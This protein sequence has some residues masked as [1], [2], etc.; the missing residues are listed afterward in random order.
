VAAAL[1]AGFADVVS[2]DDV[3]AALGG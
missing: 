2:V 1:A 3:V